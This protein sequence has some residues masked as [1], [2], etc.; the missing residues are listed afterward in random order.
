MKVIILKPNVV[1]PI[2]APPNRSI[3][4]WLEWAIE[5]RSPLVTGKQEDL[6]NE[7]DIAATKILRLGARWEGILDRTNYPPLYAGLE[8]PLPPETN[9]LVCAALSCIT[10]EEYPQEF[11][12]A[13][14]EPWFGKDLPIN[15]PNIESGIIDR[16]TDIINRSD[17]KIIV[18]KEDKD[19]A[20][21]PKEKLHR[22][23]RGEI[24]IR[25]IEAGV[26]T[27]KAG[28]FHIATDGYWL[29]LPK[30]EGGIYDII[31]SC[32]APRFGDPHG[33]TYNGLA[34][35]HFNVSP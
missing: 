12:G 16:A 21:Y 27:D 23:P 5:P 30:L 18:K 24:E 11:P 20:S 19:L 14:N 6:L 3:N 29:Y 1:G 32:S 22:M 17:A 28:Y 35:Y 15:N 31:V 34:A 4:E 25:K 7:N 9:V 2:E 33:S 8:K 10:P 26:W 13:E